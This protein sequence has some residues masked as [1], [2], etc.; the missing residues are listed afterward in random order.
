MW[1]SQRLASI[2][3]ESGQ[4]KA[5]VRRRDR[6]RGE[7]DPSLRYSKREHFSHSPDP[8][9]QLHHYLRHASLWERLQAMTVLSMLLVVLFMVMAIPVRLMLTIQLLIYGLRSLHFHGPGKHLPSLTM[10]SSM[11]LVAMRVLTAMPGLLML[12]IHKQILG[13][14]RPLCQLV[15]TISLLQLVSSFHEKLYNR[16]SGHTTPVAPAD[17]LRH[18]AFLASAPAAGAPLDA[19]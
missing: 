15:A 16:G 8:G 12:T 13:Q 18:R 14:L 9:Q 3:L 4:R 10:V 5:Q 17:P 6:A 19:R 7:S 2:S 11:L 1:P